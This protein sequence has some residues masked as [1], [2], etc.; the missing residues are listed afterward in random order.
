MKEKKPVKKFHDW[1]ERAK[2]KHPGNMEQFVKAEIARRDWII[3]TNL[4]K[5]I[6]VGIE[7]SLANDVLLK[8]KGMAPEPNEMD[9]LSLLADFHV[10][11]QDKL[12][13]IDGDYKS[14]EV[15]LRPPMS[16]RMFL[17][18][19]E[20]RRYACDTPIIPFADDDDCGDG[21]STV[22]IAAPA[23]E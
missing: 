16:R 9:V 7:R 20:G 3:Y 21:S 8:T 10:E 5:R 18:S 12:A 2:A 19:D 23:W 22:T 14:A 13:Q 15:F 1:R 11:Y 17:F 6:M 4:T